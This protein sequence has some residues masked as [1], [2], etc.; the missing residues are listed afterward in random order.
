ML[1][2]IRSEIGASKAF[3][4]LSAR[5]HG[6]WQLVILA[7]RHHRIPVPPHFWPMD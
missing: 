2:P 3:W 1:A 5:Q 4:A 7:S 6:L